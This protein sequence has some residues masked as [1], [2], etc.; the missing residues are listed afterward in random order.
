MLD[1]LDRFVA[2]LSILFLLL[3]IGSTLFI[4]DTGTLKPFR[5]PKE[6]FILQAGGLLGILL[7]VRFLINS[8]ARRSLV[9]LIPLVPLG[10]L[11]VWRMSSAWLD[12]P[13]AAYGAGPNLEFH[14]IL[15]ICLFGLATFIFFLIGAGQTLKQKQARRVTFFLVLF[16]LVEVLGVFVEITGDILGKEW[17]PFLWQ[18]TIETDQGELKTSYFG[19]LGNTNF[20]AGYLAILFF[21]VLPVRSH[22]SMGAS[23]IAGMHLP[24]AIL[25]V[26]LVC[27]S[28]GALLGLAFGGLI[29]GIANLMLKKNLRFSRHEKRSGPLAWKVAP[30]VLIGLFFFS[31]IVI[32]KGYRKD[33]T[34]ALTLRGESISKRV[35]L[36]YTGLEMLKE[37]PYVGIGPGSFRLQFLETVGEILESDRGEAFRSRVQNLKS[38]KPVHLHNDPLEVLVEWGIVGY[39]SMAAFVV[40][41]FFVAFRKMGKDPPGLA[42]RRA[43]WI[44]GVSAGLGY[45]LFEFP[46]HLPPHLV[47]SAAL[48]G[49]SVASTGSASKERFSGWGSVPGLLTGILS[50]LL[51]YHAVHLGVA[52]HLAQAAWSGPKTKKSEINQ[53]YDRAKLASLLDPANTEIALL[54]GQFQWRTQ[55]RPSDAIITLRKAAPISD[56]PLISLLQAQIALDQNRIQDAI[57]AITPLEGVADFLPGVGFIRGQIAQRLGNEPDAADAFLRDIRASSRFSNPETVTLDLPGL[58]LKYGDVLE[59]L[60]NYREA[61]WQYEKYNDLIEERGSSIPIGYLRLGQIYRDQFSDYQSAKQY[62]EDALES[63]EKNASHIE[64]RAVKDEIRRLNELVLQIRKDNQLQIK[65]EREP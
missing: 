11:G 26:L 33:W 65:E 56:D 41:A 18:A 63:A 27:L 30:L 20:L 29:Y 43:G 13:S 53:A 2:R 40:I 14:Y 32:E 39:G 55:N 21:V 58:Y 34:S 25:I 37:S 61:V 15:R 49:L 24:L 51:L 3:G 9:W 22:K 35:F 6:F 60:G 52:S 8:D 64:I 19:S 5:D 4:V 54:L 62:F 59:S 48:L 28:K 47:L 42:K 17:H 23:P 46:F 36:A 44:A 50:V 45:S 12:G 31:A 7:A 10:S 38:F 1:N 57:R 16:G